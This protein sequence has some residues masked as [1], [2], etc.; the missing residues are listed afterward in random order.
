[1]TAP[2]VAAASLAVVAIAM[3]VELRVSRVNE[4]RLLALGAVAPPDPVYRTMRW[5]YPGVFAL[6]AR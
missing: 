2:M 4:R 5:A 1:M 6:M 3:L